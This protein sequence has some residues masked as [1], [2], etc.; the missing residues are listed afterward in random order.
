MK[1]VSIVVCMCA[2]ALVV[3]AAPALA[4]GQREQGELSFTAGWASEPALVGQPN[5][6][7]LIVERGGEPVE[8]AEDTLKVT[9]SVGEETTD[10]LALRTVFD[11]PGEY[12]A[13]M[14]PTVVGGYTFH[15]TGTIGETRVDQ[16][17]T[18]PKDGFD[19]VSGTSDIAFPKQAPTT[20]ELT[21]KLE[22]VQRDADDAQDAVAMARM[23][24]IGGLVVGIAGIALALSRR[25]A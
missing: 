9:V 1:K 11:A 2:A 3:T 10:P 15:F 18:S 19:E 13:D 8:G 24:A 14:I 25:R 4:H 22:A 16:S 7:Q 12:R 5:A 17:F 21:E 23:L 20:T 6:V